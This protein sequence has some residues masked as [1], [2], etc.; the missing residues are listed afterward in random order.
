[1]A[2]AA[3]WGAHHVDPIQLILLGVVAAA[4]PLATLAQDGPRPGPLQARGG[5]SLDRMTQAER[6]D[7]GVQ[8]TKQLH[9]GPIHGLTPA[10]IP[11]GQERCERRSQRGLDRRMAPDGTGGA[12]GLE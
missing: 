9:G 3:P 1:V 4:V 6:Q 12:I 8:P 11:G 2:A 7:L 5:V 10:S